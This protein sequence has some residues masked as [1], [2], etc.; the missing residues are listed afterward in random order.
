MD[1]FLAAL[2]KQICPNPASLDIFRRLYV[3][4]P[5]VPPSPSGSPLQTKVGWGL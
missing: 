3:P 2:A 1:D 4:P 5:E